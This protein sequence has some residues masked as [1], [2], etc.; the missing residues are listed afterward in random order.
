MCVSVRHRWRHKLVVFSVLAKSLSCVLAAG[1][2]VKY[3]LDGELFAVAFPPH[4][5]YSHSHA[6]IYE[7][8]YEYE[9]GGVSLIYVRN[10]ISRSFKRIFSLPH[11]A[12]HLIPR[13]S[14]CSSPSPSH[15]P[16]LC[17]VYFYVKRIKKSFLESAH[18]L[19]FIYGI[20]SGRL[21]RG[22]GLA[23]GMGSRM[24]KSRRHGYDEMGA[25]PSTSSL[26]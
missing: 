7:Y 18:K 13:L 21:G 6:R 5:A 14:F 11:L 20:S 25:L 9:F 22:T 15:F 26:P 4:I 24:G 23:L 3:M 1:A 12:S 2:W 17:V 19:I 8:E 10:L 16:T